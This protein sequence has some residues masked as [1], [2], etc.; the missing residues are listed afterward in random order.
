LPVI[1]S[2]QMQL[3]T[4]ASFAQPNLSKLSVS[5]DEGSTV[6]G[7]KHE[8]QG[9]LEPGSDPENNLGVPLLRHL[10]SDQKQFWKTPIS[11]RAKDLRWVAPFSGFTAALIAGDS[12]FSKQVP[13]EPSQLKRSLNISNYG[14]YSLIGLGGASFLFGHLQHNDHLQEAG[15]LSGEAAINSTAVAYLL[16]ESTR[17][18]RPI[19]GNGNGDFF[20]GGTSF[21]SEH[22]AIA[23]SVASVWA[24]EY[25]GILSQIA[26]YGLAT[27]VTATR[28]TAKQHFPS[29][30]LVGSALGWYFGRQVFRAHHDPE[31][32]GGA[33]GNF[34]EESADRP[35]SAS[36]M[37]SPYVPVD[38]WIYPA[39][40]RLAALGYVPTVFLSQRPWTRIECARILA[41]LAGQ[42]SEDTPVQLAEGYR[43]LAQEFALESARLN[44]APNL[45]LELN[46]VYARVTNIAGRP[47]RDGYHF[48][49]TTTND[50]GRPYGRGTNLISG[51]SASAAAGPFAF[52]VRGEYQQAPATPSAPQSVL[53]AIADADFTLP[54]SNAT[55]QAKRFDLL[56]GSIS[57]N[58][59][60][61]QLSFGKQSQWMGSGESGP[62]LLSNNAEPIL[63]FKIDTVSPITIPLFSRILGTA[64]SEFFLGHLSGHQFEYNSPHLIGPGDITPQPY[65][66]GT[67]LSFKPTA[68]FEFGMGFTA[69]FAGPG[70]PFTWTNFA[71]TFYAHTTTGLN[72]AKRI[73][74]A[75]FI[76]RVPHLRK[77]LTVYMDSL[78]V[79]E[80][81]PIG[82][83]RPSISP[84]IYIPQLPKLPQFEIRAEG[85]KESLATEFPP[86]FVYY[87]VDRFRSGYTNENLL[88]ANWIGR[89]GHGGQ[90]WLTYHFSLRNIIQ[91][92]YRHQEVSRDFIK[93]GRLIDYSAKAD[94]ML[95]PNMHFAGYLQY[96]QWT[97][98]V[99]STTR[100]SNLLASI[101]MTFEP[102]WGLHK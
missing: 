93:G 73:S 87:G 10:I 32:G 80:Y 65:M 1:A 3:P 52:Y 84:G 97:F 34:L 60:D 81:S 13:D 89:A 86:G 4:P 11:F 15:L 72:P 17:R 79:D 25:P 40:E 38:S 100:Q 33:W 42:L 43:Q 37:A 14:A 51:A 23:W 96:E 48:G 53:Q 54:V 16:K 90:G 68:N 12:W 63:M 29:D 77:W 58:L 102:H 85:I 70:L 74:E 67:K 71:R 101:Q 39:F 47:L 18:Q 78:V 49:Q 91:L 41:D 94:V 98:P 2:G 95:S 6:P 22:S 57:L 26:A 64:K 99:L 75:D 59:H 7:W 76:Y 44:G 56:E 36:Y 66:H 69:Q 30:V 35:R 9:W 50:F 83:T 28:V 21:P 46:S 62:F 27:A 31:L 61:V 19:E 92:G 82:S 45:G 8:N 5:K 20:R 24:H 88:M 55:L